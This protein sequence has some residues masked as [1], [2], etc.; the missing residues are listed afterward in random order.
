MGLARDLRLDTCR[1]SSSGA[2]YQ[3]VPTQDVSGGKQSCSP[4]STSYEYVP[5]SSKGLNL[6]SSDSPRR[7]A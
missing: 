7:A 4:S 5:V 3:R 2:L 6:S 1:G